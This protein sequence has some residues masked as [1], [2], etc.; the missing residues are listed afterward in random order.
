MIRFLAV[1]AFAL[2]VAT[3]AQASRSRPF[4]SQTAW[5]RTSAKPVAWVC[6]IVQTLVAA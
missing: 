4:T 2:A 5:S 1:T 3:S 6:T